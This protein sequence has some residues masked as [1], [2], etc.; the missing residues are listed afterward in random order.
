MPHSGLG[1]DFR[2]DCH[3]WSVTRI[4]K[5]PPY[6]PTVLPTVG[7]M[8]YPVPGYPKIPLKASGVDAFDAGI[9]RQVRPY[10]TE[11]FN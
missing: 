9:E 6:V 11:C 3:Y 4:R 10:L 1:R 7:A 8:E 5:N 2:F